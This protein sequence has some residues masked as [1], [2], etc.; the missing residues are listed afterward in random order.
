MYHQVHGASVVKPPAVPRNLPFDH[1]TSHAPLQN[2]VRSFYFMFASFTWL[3]G[4]SHKN[5]FLPT[6]MKPQRWLT[7]CCFE[8]PLRALRCRCHIHYSWRNRHPTNHLH[9]TSRTS[10]VEP[11]SCTS[12]CKIGHGP[13]QSNNATDISKYTLEGNNKMIN[14]H[15]NMMC[16]NRTSILCIDPALIPL[17]G[18]SANNKKICAMKP[19]IC[20]RTYLLVML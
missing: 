1:I 19:R 17:L 6:Y 5:R 15:I 16:S 11:V 20:P 13:L 2:K 10:V 14:T 9:D 12:T 18:F 3:L 8:S 4:L 7:Y